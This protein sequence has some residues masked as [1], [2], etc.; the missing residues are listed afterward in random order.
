MALKSC[1]AASAPRWPALWISAAATDSGKGSS[2]SST[3]TRRSMVTNMIPKMPPTI[4]R[5]LAST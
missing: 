5:A 1:T 3:M 4:M 2:G